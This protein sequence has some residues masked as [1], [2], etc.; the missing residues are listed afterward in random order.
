MTICLSG[1]P[2]AAIR[3]AALAFTALVPLSVLSQ[4]ALAQ[5][6]AD[7]AY[8]LDI[9]AQTLARSLASLSTATGL[10]VVYADDEPLSVNAP[11]IKGRMTVEQALVRVTAGTGFTFRFSGPG[12]ITLVK[13]RK[14]ADGDQV[15]G[16]VRV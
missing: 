6:P 3:I 12:V 8:D 11:A 9:P 1:R 16:A 5:R 7:R 14:K 2:R 10:Q 15:T 13:L 4:P